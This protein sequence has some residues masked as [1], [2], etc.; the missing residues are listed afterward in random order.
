VYT[1]ALLGLTLYP[2][3]RLLI[4]E[5]PYSD[6]L[7]GPPPYLFPVDFDAMIRPDVDHHVMRL[8]LRSPAQPWLSTRCS[9]VMFHVGPPLPLD[10]PRWVWSAPCK[11]DFA[12]QQVTGSDKAVKVWYPGFAPT[13]KNLPVPPR[14]AEPWTS[15]STPLWITRMGLSIEGGIG[16]KFALRD[17]RIGTMS[18]QQYHPFDLRTADAIPLI[19]GNRGVTTVGHCVAGRVAENQSLYW[20]DT[21][22][23]LGWT[24]LNGTTL[25][26][27][28]RHLKPGPGGS[29]LKPTSELNPAAWDGKAKAALLETRI[30]WRTPYPNADILEPWDIAF[31][32]G[33]QVLAK[34]PLVLMTDTQPMTGGSASKTGISCLI[35]FDHTPVH[36]GG[37]PDAWVVWQHPVKGAEMWGIDRNPLTGR[38]HVTSCIGNDEWA[39]DLEGAF[40]GEPGHLEFHPEAVKAERVWVSAY[41]PTLAHLGLYERYVQKA[42]DPAVYRSKY[43]IDGPAGTAASCFPQSLRFMSDGSRLIAE[44]Y[45]YSIRRRDAANRTTLFANHPNSA[46]KGG[47]DWVMDINQD[48][49]TGPKDLVRTTTWA[50]DMAA[51]FTA[52]GVYRGWAIPR[53]TTVANMFLVEGPT[54][55]FTGASYPWMITS[56][57]GAVWFAPTGSNGLYRMTKRQPTD[58]AI[59]VSLYTRGRQLYRSA[60]PSFT[61]SHGEDFQGQFGLPVPDELA[62]MSDPDLA[63]YWRAGLGTGIPRTFTDAD[64]AALIYYTRWNA[65][66]PSGPPPPPP[67]TQTLR[68]AKTL[69]LSGS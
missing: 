41:T 1:P 37:Q 10:L 49:T 43:D 63:A 29:Q 35:A 38:Y 20:L 40:T 60:A 69:T 4:D 32:T 16:R 12:Y 59:N 33:G 14:V 62:A 45:T 23:R 7:P 5:E 42:G 50:M 15:L 64:V 51:Q 47:L 30:N 67:T 65:V 2:E 21:N 48:G 56:G 54:E 26:I 22:W 53:A 58:P 46:V 68:V 18:R 17:G 39:L 19:D 61:L 34:H 9:N 13:P 28:G 27:A 3:A 55:Y 52:D 24:G 25:T 66:P 6:W 44:R 31:W 57:Q 8:E 11:F 36:T